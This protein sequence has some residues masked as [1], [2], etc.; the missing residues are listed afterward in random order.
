MVWVSQLFCQRML[1]CGALQVKK[2]DCISLEFFEEEVE[3]I[4]SEDLFS[5]T[6]TFY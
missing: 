3:T 4:G 5:K 2:D 1:F 6:L